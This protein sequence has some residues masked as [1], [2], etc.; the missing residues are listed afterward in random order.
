MLLLRGLRGY[1]PLNEEGVRKFLRKEYLIYTNVT[2]VDENTDKGL[3]YD[4]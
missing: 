1:V 4:S 2:L 3:I